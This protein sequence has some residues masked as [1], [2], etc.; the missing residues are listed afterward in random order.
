MAHLA[1]CFTVE[2]IRVVKF[3]VSENDLA[4]Q[5]YHNCVVVRNEDQLFVCPFN[6]CDFID[7][8]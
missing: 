3:M 2:V 4:I 6:K 1:D 8:L 7:V 5:N